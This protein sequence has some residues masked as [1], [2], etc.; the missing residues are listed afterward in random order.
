MNETFVNKDMT[1]KHGH[2]L[3]GAKKEN[4]MIISNSQIRVYIYEIIDHN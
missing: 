3:A 1:P 4:I 2:G